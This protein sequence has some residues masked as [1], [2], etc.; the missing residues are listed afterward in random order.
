[1]TNG[2]DWV[3]DA[4]GFSIESTRSAVSNTSSSMKKSSSKSVN[5]SVDTCTDP[6][7]VRSSI[8]S[9][10]ILKFPDRSDSVSGFGLDLAARSISNVSNCS[11]STWLISPL[12]LAQLLRIWK[13]G[14]QIDRQNWL[15]GLPSNRSP[16]WSS[17]VQPG[18]NSS[19]KPIWVSRSIVAWAVAIIVAGTWPCAGMLAS[20]ISRFKTT[21]SKPCSANSWWTCFIS[22]QSGKY[23]S[24]TRSWR[25]CSRWIVNWARLPPWRSSSLPNSAISRQLARSSPASKSIW[26]KLPSSSGGAISRYRKSDSKSSKATA[27]YNILFAATVTAPPLIVC[28][29]R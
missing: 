28:T 17:S 22:F 19:S 12:F 1:M 21:S 26:L 23:R 10:S 20:S 25:V 27:P 4:T 13:Y 2:S 15:W 8:I 24:L 14:I 11:S 5:S 18:D 3:N 29:A 7:E 16:R 6:L 9:L